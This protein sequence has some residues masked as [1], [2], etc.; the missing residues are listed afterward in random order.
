MGGPFKGLTP[1]L[2]CKGKSEGGS[3]AYA[4]AQGGGRQTARA[5]SGAARRKR[6]HASAQAS[7]RLSASTASACV[8]S[9]RVAR[10]GPR[11]REGQGVTW[12]G[13]WARVLVGGVAL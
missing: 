3:D 9:G 8:A 7:R 6:R 12:Q 13:M 10:P 4:G 5:W 1:P 2:W 11:R